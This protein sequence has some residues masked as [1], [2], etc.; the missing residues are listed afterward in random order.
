MA[1]QGHHYFFLL[2]PN[3]IFLT[4]PSKQFS[5]LAFKIQL[6]ETKGAR[7]IVV[8]VFICRLPSN[9]LKLFK[10][11]RDDSRFAYYCI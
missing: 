9:N 8:K 6:L 3:Q 7:S 5:P 10:I 4:S 1:N 2:M 11:N